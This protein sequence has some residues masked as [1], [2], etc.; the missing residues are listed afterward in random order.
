MLNK[1]HMCIFLFR[2]MTIKLVLIVR[3]FL[4]F[5]F[6]EKIQFPK[7]LIYLFWFS[8]NINYLKHG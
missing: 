3:D 7:N 2:K 6:L 4:L 1:I 8:I 5:I